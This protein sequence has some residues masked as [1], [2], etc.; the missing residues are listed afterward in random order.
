WWVLD[1]TGIQRSSAGGLRQLVDAGV[2]VNLILGEG[3]YR[4]LRT[5][6]G[7]HLRKMQRGAGFHVDV[8]PD[9]DHSMLQRAPRRLAQ[10][11]LLERVLALSGGEALNSPSSPS[12]VA[13]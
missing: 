1:R 11:H 7:W 10:D 5:R 9:L 12:T 2:E 6:A 3:E 4:P 8:V 13:P